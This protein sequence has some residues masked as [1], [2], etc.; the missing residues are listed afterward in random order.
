[1]KKASLYS[2]GASFGNPGPAGIGVH[3]EVDGKVR[4]I[5]EHIGTATNNVAEYSALVRGLEEALRLGAREVEA[6]LDSELLVKQIKGEYKIK[7]KG[8][9]PYY[10]KAMGLIRSFER[11]SISH[12]R[13]EKNERADRLS[14]LGAGAP[15]NKRTSPGGARGQ[16]QLF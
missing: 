10:Q 7:N 9:I 13:R 3:L 15:D 1:M 4:E 6:F 2:D 11:F 5:S 8:L 12:I 14:K 16:G